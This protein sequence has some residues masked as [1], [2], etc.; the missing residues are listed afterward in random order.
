MSWLQKY[1][2]MIVRVISILDPEAGKFGVIVTPTVVVN[3]VII[4]VRGSPDP[5]RLERLIKNQL[6]GVAQ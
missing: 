6:G 5:E 1:E 3:G 4:S 2:G